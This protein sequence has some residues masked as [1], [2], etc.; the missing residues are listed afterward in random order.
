MD[1]EEAIKKS[2]ETPWRLG[3]CSQGES[4]WCRVIKCEPLLMYKESEDSEYEEFWVVG[5]GQLQKEI[6]ERFVFLHNQ[7]L[8]SANILDKIKT[9][10]KN[11]ENKSDE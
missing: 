4:C 6:A 8:K 10:F 9:H 1:I 3:T 7:N 2:L 11:I 5:P